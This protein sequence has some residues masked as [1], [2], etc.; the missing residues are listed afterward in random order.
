[1]IHIY[2]K[3]IS[4][5]TLKGLSEV[6]IE[7][8]QCFRLVDTMIYLT[9]IIQKLKHRREFSQT[10]RVAVICFYELEDRVYQK[11]DVQVLEIVCFDY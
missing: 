2:G 6:K 8:I 1:M 9:Y 5:E 7:C 10:E 3:R 11:E 4:R